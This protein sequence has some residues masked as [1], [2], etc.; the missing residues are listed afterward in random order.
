M[1]LLCV[2]RLW[3]YRLQAGP[4]LLLPD[5]PQMW[6]LPLFVGLG[7]SFVHGLFMSG[8]QVLCRK[9]RRISPHNNKTALWPFRLLNG[10]AKLCQ[11]THFLFFLNRLVGDIL[12]C[13]GFLSYLGPFNQIFRNLLLKDQWEI[14]LRARKIPFTENLNLISMLVDP[15]TVSITFLIVLI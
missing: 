3:T 4:S 5:G 14:E 8:H 9:Q 7:G 13:T 1:C 6:S 12:L 11:V 2:S 10:R 15:P